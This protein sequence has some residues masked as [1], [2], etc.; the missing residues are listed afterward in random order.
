MKAIPS[1]RI[2]A[3]SLVGPCLTAGCVNT[4]TAVV[5]TSRPAM[6]AFSRTTEPTES[7]VQDLVVAERFVEAGQYQEAIRLY[8]ELLAQNPTLVDAY[9]GLGSVYQRTDNLAAAEVNFARAAR[10]EPDSFDAQAGHGMVLQSLKRYPEAVAAYQRALLI[11]STSLQANLGAAK[12]LVEMRRP[13][14]ALRFAREAVRLAPEDVTVRIDL[15]DTLQRAD[16]PDEAID[17]LEVAVELEEIDE[18]LLLRLVGAYI[19]AGRWQEAANA[20]ETLVEIAPSPVAYEHLGRAFFRLGDSESSMQ[21]YREAVELDPDHW[22]SLNGVGV[23][24]LNAWL[25]SDRS[26]VEMALEARSA[27][28]SSLRVNPDQPKVVEILTKYPI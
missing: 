3:L 5:R 19:E 28:Y 23:N 25:R 17:E 15:A 21:A 14:A 8:E 27:F 18:A 24:A 1:I 10:L 20:G 2:I 13:K 11:D 7:Q 4:D 12:S 9:L 16:L 26:D 22:P 6:T